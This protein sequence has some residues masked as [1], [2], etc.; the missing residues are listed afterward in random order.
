VTGPADPYALLRELRREQ[1]K[2]A[3]PEPAPVDV[4]K[5]MP[6][7]TADLGP[8]DDDQRHDLARAL[9]DTADRAA[10]GSIRPTHP[11]IATLRELAAA[12]RTDRPVKVRVTGLDRDARATLWRILGIAVRGG[13]TG[14]A[15]VHLRALAD[16][17]ERFTFGAGGYQ[18]D[19][20]ELRRRAQSWGPG[21]SDLMR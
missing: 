18:P 6:T 20:A 3:P 13:E 16:E 21:G 14:P 5:T 9:R 1:R 2:P 15:S 7:F 17:W 4:T 8:L 11:I 19:D 12:A 10:A